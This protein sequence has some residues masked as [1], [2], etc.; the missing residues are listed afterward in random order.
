[1]NLCING[2]IVR[3]N[4][5]DNPFNPDDDYYV[6]NSNQLQISTHFNINIRCCCGICKYELAC[7]YKFVTF[8]K[9]PGTINDKNIFISMCPLW[10][11]E[12]EI[13]I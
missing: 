10:R 3:L 9:Y 6:F 12:V 11:C 4:Q 2:N 5:K 13:C 7:G 1:M 8:M